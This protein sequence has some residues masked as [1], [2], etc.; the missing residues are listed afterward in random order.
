MKPIAKIACAVISLSALAACTAGSADAQHM[1]QNGG[2]SQFL[3]GVWHGLIAPVTLLIEVVNKFAPHGTPWPLHMIEKDG[4]V[5]Y[6]LGF[7]LGMAG[8]PSALFV[9]SRRR[10]V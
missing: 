1:A 7:F 4:G 3:L 8:G 9:S 10:V 6:D 2:V 5:F